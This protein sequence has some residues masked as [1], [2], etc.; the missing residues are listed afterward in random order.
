[1]TCATTSKELI[2]MGKLEEGF[3]ATEDNLKL[4]CSY[5]NVDTENIA[6]TEKILSCFFKNKVS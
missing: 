1:M 6:N 3:P 2:K 4:L 5:L